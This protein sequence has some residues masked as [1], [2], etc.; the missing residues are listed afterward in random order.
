M[1]VLEQSSHYKLLV[2]FFIVVVII[3]VVLAVV[4]VVVMKYIVIYNESSFRL[5]G[6]LGFGK[7]PH[8]QP[9]LIHGWC[10]IFFRVS[11][12]SFVPTFISQNASPALTVGANGPARLPVSLH[13]LP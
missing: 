4:V 13:P 6:G 9:C 10:H 2:V 12:L 7:S 5:G 1:S 11:Q 3:I 8:Q